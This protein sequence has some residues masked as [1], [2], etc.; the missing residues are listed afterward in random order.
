MGGGGVV[1]R[2]RGG[3]GLVLGCSVR[4]LAGRVGVVRRL[5]GAA[6]IPPTIDSSRGVVCL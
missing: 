5:K 2:M 6:P 3:G 1:G 4:G